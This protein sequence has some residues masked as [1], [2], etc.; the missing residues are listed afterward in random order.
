MSCSRS[1]SSRSTDETLWLHSVY[2]IIVAIVTGSNI[3]EMELVFENILK[4]SRD[5]LAVEVFVM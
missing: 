2:R 1:V 3:F 4:D 5:G